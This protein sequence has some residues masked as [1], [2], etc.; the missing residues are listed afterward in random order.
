[1][2]TFRQ[3]DQP[4]PQTARWQQF[5]QDSH[6]ARNQPWFG[7]PK[8]NRLKENYRKYLNQKPQNPADLSVSDVIQGNP[9][10]YLLEE[11]E[12]F[13]P[14]L[15]ESGGNL[16][17]DS[18]KQQLIDDRRYLHTGTKNKFLDSISQKGFTKDFNNTE[19]G[20]GNAYNKILHDPTSLTGTYFGSNKDG[21]GGK[22]LAAK[23]APKE[24]G[25]IL[26]AILS[27]DQGKYLTQ[28]SKYYD[29][30][31]YRFEHFPGKYHSNLDVPLG[32]YL[33]DQEVDD[34]HLEAQWNPVVEHLKETAKNP[35]LP[36]NL[37]Q[38]FQNPNTIPPNQI[39]FPPG[40]KKTDYENIKKIFHEEGLRENYPLD[41]FKQKFDKSFE[42]DLDL[43]ENEEKHGL[44][45]KES[46]LEKIPK[47][48]DLNPQEFRNYLKEDLSDM[49]M[50]KPQ[51]NF[52][53][54]D[55]LDSSQLLNQPY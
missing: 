25:S 48:K 42:G 49:G 10:Q 28:D 21:L 47:I 18:A 22:K 46:D 39:G 23:Y 13:F 24:D 34:S 29:Q 50:P 51:Q 17:F 7:N 15:N 41:L 36:Q 19:G 11:E 53:F 52:N 55:L 4:P 43:I 38:H 27:K 6:Q 1:M 5:L 33:I 40:I 44:E 54:G 35:E 37:N 20:S 3:F 32:D 26:R 2:S 12:D 16:S 45:E 9:P 30:P 14:D 8:T 31:S